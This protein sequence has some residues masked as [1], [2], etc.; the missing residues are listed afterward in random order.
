VVFSKMLKKWCCDLIFVKPATI[1][2]WQRAGIKIP[3][4]CHEI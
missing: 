1:I 2:K 4:M 3:D